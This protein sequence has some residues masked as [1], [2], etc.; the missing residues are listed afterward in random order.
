MKR[1]NKAKI[2]NPGEAEKV[3]RQTVLSMLPQDGS[4]IRWT[5]LEKKARECGMSL[6]TLR[7]HLDRLEEAGRVVRIV[8]KEEK[9]PGVYFQLIDPTLLKGIYANLPKEFMNIEMWMDNIERL[10]GKPEASETLDA[11][12]KTQLMLLNSEL[13]HVWGKALSLQSD[14]KAVAFIKTMMEDYIHPIVNNLGLLLRAHAEIADNVL[15][16][17]LDDVLAG[18]AP[19]ERKWQ[20]IL[21]KLR[22]GVKRKRG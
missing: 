2:L 12:L 7:K 3:A 9:P 22:E 16:N 19:I 4:E 20:R 15:D 14:E 10:K 5:S 1:K 18:L 6:R 13:I 21:E 11:L 8:K 17:L